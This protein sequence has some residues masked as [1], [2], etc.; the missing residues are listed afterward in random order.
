MLYPSGAFMARVA[1]G[2]TGRAT[3]PFFS[4]AVIHDPALAAR[5]SRAHEEVMRSGETEGLLEP[6]ADLLRRYADGTFDPQGA[7]LEPAKVRRAREYLDAH[8]FERVDLETLAAFIDCSPYHLLRAFRRETGLT[9]HA[10]GLQVRVGRAK[11]EL[12]K[13]EPAA[14][15]AAQ[16]GFFD[17]SHFGSSFKKLV[18]VT[19]GEY[20]RAAARAA[21]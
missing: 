17:Q 15:V 12:A 1:E 13:G 18:G 21:R 6:L 2:V 11:V 7:G 9:P 5:L 10:Y 8:P 4:P 16:T 14:L 19:P 3:L 20:I